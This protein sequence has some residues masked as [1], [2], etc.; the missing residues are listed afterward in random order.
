MGK[1][2]TLEIGGMTCASCANSL[3]K[4][5]SD[6]EG[7]VKA[8]VNFAN[9]YAYIE[10]ENEDL[11]IE[12]FRDAVESTG[13]DFKGVKGENKERS[14]DVEG[15]TCASCAKS[16][17]ES[18]EGIDGVE[19]ANVNFGTEKARVLYD[20]NKVSGDEFKKAVE[21][22]GYSIKTDEVRDEV[23]KVLRRT[24]IGWLIT[25]PMFAWMLPSMLFGITWPNEFLF[26][27]GMLVLSTLVLT[28]AGKET[29]KSAINSLSHG[30]ANMDV[31]IALGAFSGYLT[32]ILTFFTPLLNFSGVGAMIMT[33]HVT[34]R[35]IEERAKGR[36]SE[37]IEKLMELEAS[38]ATVIED[39]EEKE[40][41]VD[42][43][44]PGDVMLVR[45]GEKIPT[46]GEVVDGFSA[47][48]ESMVSG[49]S[50]P[51]EK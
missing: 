12:D 1:E 23:K 32:G 7:V 15:M 41:S 37:A 17:E 16:I 28:L 35:Y 9:G 38:T 10:Y 34:G 19:E 5:F 11:E 22:A 3:K 18:L 40:V 13:Y 26:N 36:A 48:D 45:P 21:D 2:I 49:E 43:I 33:F 27:T 24:K 47:V 50:V 51:V 14:F 29:F 30:S 31:L 25:A 4:A 42:K 6:L 44:E 20:G 8:E 39:G 46:D